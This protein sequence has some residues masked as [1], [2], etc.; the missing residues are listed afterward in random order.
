ME[1]DNVPSQSLY[2]FA[3]LHPGRGV[4][5]LKVRSEDRGAG[6]MRLGELLLHGSLDGIL[7]S[8]IDD[9]SEVEDTYGDV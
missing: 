1:K 4:W 3:A 2:R 5:R 7:I 6:T 9:G 8:S